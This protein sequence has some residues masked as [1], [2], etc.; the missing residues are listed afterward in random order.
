MFHHDF[1]PEMLGLGI[2]ETGRVQGQLTRRSS[3]SELEAAHDA[4][5]QLGFRAGA[6]ERDTDPR[7]D[8]GDAPCDFEQAQGGEFGRGERLRPRDRVIPNL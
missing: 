4:T 8:F 7:S 3:F 2:G 1:G 5:E 6:S